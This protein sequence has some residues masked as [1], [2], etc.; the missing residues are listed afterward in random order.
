[1]RRALS[2]RTGYWG[3]QKYPVMCRLTTTRADGQALLQ[4]KPA[5]TFLLRLS[6]VQ[7]S[8]AV[9]YVKADQ[10]A[11]LVSRMCARA[12]ILRACRGRPSTMCRLLDALFVVKQW[13]PP[14]IPS[15][16]SL[17]ES[18][19]ARTNGGDSEIPSSFSATGMTDFQNI[20]N[21]FCDGMPPSARFSLL[22]ARARPVQ[23]QM[24]L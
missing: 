13:F 11:S 21:N 9:M 2:Q 12:C 8:L 14:W 1:M 22:C 6:S 19:G 5:G 20:V 16:L 15:L 3:F 24:F 7:G 23:Q 4:G 10:Q 17:A 18:V